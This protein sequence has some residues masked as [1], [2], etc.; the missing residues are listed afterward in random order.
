MFAAAPY[1]VPEGTWVATIVA[2]GSGWPSASVILPVRVDVVTWA[3]MVAVP[4][5]SNK[6]M[7]MNLSFRMIGKVRRFMVVVRYKLF[8]IR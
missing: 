1:R 5:N 3:I 6:G 4:M 8:M 2:P 7:K